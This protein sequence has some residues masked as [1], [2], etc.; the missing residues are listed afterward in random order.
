[1]K[2]LFLTGTLFLISSIVFGQVQIEPR[3]SNVLIEFGINA[4]DNNNK[5]NLGVLPFINQKLDFKTPFYISGE[6]RFHSNFSTSLA[7]TTNQLEIKTRTYTYTA[8]DISGK[9]YFSDYLFNSKDVETYVGLGLGSFFLKDGNNTFNFS[10]GAQ[11]W[12]SDHLG[13]STQLIGKIGI[14]P[15]DENVRNNYQLNLG[16][17]WRN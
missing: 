2:S 15:I 4:I 16:L 1:M 14:A 9:Y 6:Y 3:K 12:F 5:S 8:I 17:V 13:A 10:G 11:Y 7:L